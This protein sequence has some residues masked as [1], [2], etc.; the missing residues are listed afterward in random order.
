MPD[1]NRLSVLI[2]AI[3]LAYALA[4]LLE[5]QRYSFNFNVLGLAI[6]LPMNLNVAATLMASGLTAAG[7]DWLL[8]SHPHFK[9]GN[10]FQHWILPA[11]TAFV[12]GVPL[13]NLPLGPAWWLIFGL[14]GVLLLL[15]FLAE[16]IALDLSDIRHP[17]ASAGLV[18][19]S[20]TMFLILMATLA[21]SESRL[22]LAAMFVFPAAGMVSLRALH[23][24]TG[25]WE[26]AWAFG[27]ALILTQFASALHYWPLEP[28]QYG[29]ALLGPL[30]ALT[31]LALNL[32]EELS[33]RRA[34]VEAMIG[35]AMFWVA[36]ILVRG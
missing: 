16:Y 19:L 23:L 28:V 15:V 36:A 17:A 13:Y 3:L 4:Q 9:A 24:R 25:K 8:R 30:Y 26:F 11:L 12:L 5:T 31:E 21:F 27:I 6:S 22:V 35:L 10:T 29:L 1:A 33:P 18:A 2:A 34:G 14:G 20:Y 7:M 32:G